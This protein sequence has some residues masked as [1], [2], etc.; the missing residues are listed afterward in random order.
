MKNLIVLLFVLLFSAAIIVNGNVSGGG[1][2]ARTLNL[3]GD[4]Y[5]CNRA[6]PIG[7]FKAFN[8]N[9]TNGKLT[10]VSNGQTLTL[11]KQLLASEVKCGVV[12]GDRTGTLGGYL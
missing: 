2:G 3:N 12:H 6:F 10:I 4:V 11:V 1:I 9:K 8:W 7:T 5:G